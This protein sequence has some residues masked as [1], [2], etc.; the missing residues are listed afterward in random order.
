MKKPKICI[1]EDDLFYANILKNEI[2][3]N[4]LGK[5]ES[6]NSG[7]S[8]LENMNINTDIV[9][10]DY[11]LGSMFGMEILKKIKLINSEAKVIMISGHN[12]ES[13][14]VV[15]SFENGAYAYLEKDKSTLKNLKTLI[16]ISYSKEKD[17]LRYLI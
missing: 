10:L 2:L 17:N 8:F 7:E 9:L 1:V 12:N 11:N 16:D 4:N 14:V 15:R 3:K 6:F 5:V 13:S